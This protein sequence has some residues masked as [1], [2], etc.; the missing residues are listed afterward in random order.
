MIGCAGCQHPPRGPAVK[1]K[2]SSV[3]APLLESGAFAE[4]ISSCATVVVP[5]RDHSLLLFLQMSR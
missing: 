3:K 4:A 1:T 5:S 2:S